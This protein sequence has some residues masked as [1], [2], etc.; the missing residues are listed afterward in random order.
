MENQ[1]EDTDRERERVS[2]GPTERGV[3]ASLLLLLGLAE[4]RAED[5][6]PLVHTGPAKAAPRTRACLLGL[7]QR[8]LRLA[9]GSFGPRLEGSEE[10][11]LSPHEE[12]RAWGETSGWGSEMGN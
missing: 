5:G 1:I 8:M 2:G 7:R 10:G 4:L 3:N 11:K 6:L 9:A 12:A